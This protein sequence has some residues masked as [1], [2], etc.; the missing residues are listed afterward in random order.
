[1]Q[2]LGR[3]PR[4]GIKGILPISEPLYDHQ[5]SLI[6]DVL[7][8]VAFSPFYG[9]SE[10]AAFAAEV[11]GEEGLYEFNPLYGATE[12]LDEKDVPVTEPGREGRIVGTGF[13][14]SGM[15]FIR[16]DT[17]D[18]GKLVELPTRENGECLRIRSITP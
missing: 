17:G 18:F 5:R 7:G 15:P 12:L 13:L 2:R 10:K 14:S 6:R 3:T 16:Y 11:P 1:M 9:L 4:A 8:D